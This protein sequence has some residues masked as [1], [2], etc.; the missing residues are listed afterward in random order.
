MQVLS[1]YMWL[2]VYHIRQCTSR[3]LLAGLMP[4]LGKEGFE[5]DLTGEGEKL[6]IG[7]IFEALGDFRA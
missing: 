7:D 1:S 2:V 4:F 6:N 5:L 3:I